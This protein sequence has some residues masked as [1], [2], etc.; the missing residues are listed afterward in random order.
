VWTLDEA[1]REFGDTPGA[2]AVALGE[3]TAA[4]RR[5]LGL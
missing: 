2:A 3:H 1:A 5:E 4:W